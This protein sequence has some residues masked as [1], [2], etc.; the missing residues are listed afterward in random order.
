V[1]R[2]FAR[3]KL[4][5][6]A[7]GMRGAGGAARLAGLVIAAIGSLVV[8]PLGFTVLAAQHGRPDAT[9]AAVLAFTTVALL[10][11]MLPI[12][13][14]GADD[15]LD[16]ARLA[17]LPLR[18]A[19]LARGLFAA[20]L[21]GF[22]PLVTTVILLGAVVAVASGPASALAGL[23]AVAVELGLCIAG[24][25][26]VITALSATL[27]TRRGRDLGILAGGML[28]L[29]FFAA[30][31]ALSRSIASGG[32]GLWRI[33]PAVESLGSVLRWTPPGMTAHAIADASAGRYATA[34]AELAVGAGAVALL[35][36]AWIVGLRRALET[37]DASTQPRPDVRS[38]TGLRRV[39]AGLLPSGGQWAGLAW[40]S[41]ALNAAGRELRYLRRDPRRKQQLVTLAIPVFLIVANSVGRHS[42]LP[43]WPAVLAGLFA[44]LF[45]SANQ[46]GVDGVGLWLNVAATSRWQDLRAD[47]AGKN[48]AGALM[49]LPVFGVL[50]LILGVTVHDGAGAAVAFAA[51][52][53]ALGASG[54]VAAVISVLLPVP[55]PERRSSA[56]SGPGVG[57]GCLAALA[58]FAGL[59]VAALT[60]LPVF[61]AEA[62][63]PSRAWLLLIGPAYGATVLWLGRRIAAE[64]GFRRLPEILAVVSRPI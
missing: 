41:R 64:V 57:Q 4:S 31:Q 56:Y 25:R 54:G 61:L 62:A 42:E 1:A 17:L 32:L 39:V 6:I 35:C 26:A 43:T 2:L 13:T 14:F 27:R 29:G 51:L 24:S 9:G 45:S 33:S 55:F 46:F 59:G 8:M 44:G 49:T 21:I 5:L 11:L 60:V 48:L 22:G 7:G 30:N 38:P 18:P 34:A 20:A 23:A 36:F 53:C 37:A 47:I 40:S 28:S 50:Y 3:L 16:P 10:W 12:M 15:T 63:L 19:V 58:T 52:A